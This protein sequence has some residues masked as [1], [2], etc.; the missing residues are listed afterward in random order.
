R[1]ADVIRNDPVSDSSRMRL[2]SVSETRQSPGWLKVYPRPSNTF[3]SNGSC[4]EESAAAQPERAKKNTR[5]PNNLGRRECTLR[6]EKEDEGMVTQI[7]FEFN[8][9]CTR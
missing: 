5:R 3:Q 8:W 9:I 6:R 1:L 4:T 7:G 2:S